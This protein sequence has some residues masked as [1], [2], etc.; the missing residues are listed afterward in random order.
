MT[1]TSV[2]TTDLPCLYQ[3]ANRASIEAQSH[4]FA[5]LR[6][7]LLLLVVA[8]FVSYI[9]PSNI[10]GALFSASFFLI[11]LGIL[12]FIRVRRPDDIWYNGRAVAE[13]VKTI[14]WRWMMRAEPYQDCEKLEIVSKA[15]ISDQ[16]A[17]LDQNRSL[18]HVLQ[19]DC[20][21]S[22]PISNKMKAVRGL[23]VLERLS[24]YVEHRIQ[25]QENWYWHKSKLNKR[26]AKQWFWVSV[27]LHSSAILMLL[28]RIKDPS[29]SLPVE[30]VAT[31]AGAVL[32]WLQAKKHNELNSAYALTAHEIVL[33]KGESTSVQ[34]EEQL[35]DYVINSEAA[36]SREHTQ[37][38]ARKG[39]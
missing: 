25:E 8:A 26:R 27:A 39:D 7:Y 24:F 31:A 23:P 2:N 21:V 10:V 30:V 14:S 13:S 34:T 32:T 35:S 17:I 6:W 1:N 20:A 16:K 29:F 12:I 22:D 11:T 3:S 38:V 19:S 28:Y 15:F 18:S 36:F 33:I 9:C 4:Y 37:W 5:L